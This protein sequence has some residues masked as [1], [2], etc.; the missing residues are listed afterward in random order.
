MQYVQYRCSSAQFRVQV[1]EGLRDSCE[2]G[3]AGPYTLGSSLKLVSVG[4]VD[5][6]KVTRG[7]DQLLLPRGSVSFKG[8]S[9]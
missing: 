4:P 6:H 1:R 2:E 3:R 8:E 7:S 5:L 9:G